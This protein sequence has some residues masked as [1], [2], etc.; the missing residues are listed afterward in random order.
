MRRETAGTI[1]STDFQALSLFRIVFCA[2]LL[3][4]FFV[5]TYPFFTDFYSNSGVLP[6]SALAADSDRPGIVAVLPL[7]KILDVIES[8]TV[9]ALLYSVVILAFAVGYRTRWSNALTFIFNSYL[10]WRNPYLDSGAETLARLLLLWCLFLPMARYWGIDAALDPQPRDRPYPTLPFLALRVQIGSLYLFAAL[11]KV[12]GLPWRDGSALTWA[13]SDNIFGA[14]SPGLF[15]VQQAPGLLYGVNYLVIAFQLSFPFLVYCPWRNDLVR[16]LAL[17]GSASMHTSFIFFLNV[18]GFPYVCLAMLLLLIPDSWIDRLLHKRRERLAGVIIYFEPGCG[19]CHRVS[20]LL[21]EFLLSVTSTVAPASVDPTA[22]KLL[23]E[24]NSWVVRAVDGRYYLKWRAMDYLLK[25]SVLLA[26]IAWVFERKPMLSPMEKLYDLIGA[27][28]RRFGPPTANMLFP[29]KS[30]GPV[31]RPALVLCG[32]LMVLAFL[33]NVFG[34]A[35]LS[36]SELRRFDQVSAIFQV[37][38]SW[39]VFAPRPVHFQRDYHVVVHRVDGSTVNLI[40]LLPTPLF[41]S[42]ANLRVVFASPRWTKYFT[43]FDE[44][45]EETWQALGQY[46]CRQAQGQIPSMSVARQVEITLVTEPSKGTPAP[47]RSLEHRAF[48]CA[49]ASI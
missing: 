40:G 12:A 34:L 13:L 26:P 31:K 43:R 21:R 27:N 6:I 2:Y 3:G 46:L 38:Q 39:E 47:V 1:L 45:T 20:L 7:L 17:L 41:Q 30:I 23:M 32:F 5:A 18:G 8:P 15:L 16:A 44:F 37:K 35:R 42:D 22:H 33:S 19:F 29:F 24:H 48:D 49:P 10:Y 9:F 14:T 36:F 4:D 25:Q 28:R 11:F